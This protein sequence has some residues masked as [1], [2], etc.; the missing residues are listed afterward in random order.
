MENQEGNQNREK[1]P[2]SRPAGGVTG[3]EESTARTLPGQCAPHEAIICQ[4]HRRVNTH[5]R[6]RMNAQ[7][8]SFLSSHQT[9]PGRALLEALSSALLTSSW[10]HNV[11]EKEIEQNCTISTFSLFISSDVF[12]SLIFH[13]A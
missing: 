8:H 2:S 9:A 12:V 10:T 13:Q 5:H 6:P 7:Y 4:L 3:T 1:I 11:Q